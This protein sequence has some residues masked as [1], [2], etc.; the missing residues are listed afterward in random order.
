MQINSESSFKV[1]VFLT[2]L[3]LTLCVRNGSILAIYWWLIDLGDGSKNPFCVFLTAVRTCPE[4]VHQRAQ[5]VRSEGVD[6]PT[7]KDDPDGRGTWSP[8][9][10][11]EDP[12]R[13]RCRQ[14][15]VIS[16][17][18]SFNLQE[19]QSTFISVLANW[20]LYGLFWYEAKLNWILL[21]SI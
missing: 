11:V 5:S 13:D 8:I 3:I 18:E 12:Q 7:E 20:C 21:G 6:E 10:A 15:P 16:R 9:R 2:Q 4:R 1:I 19:T 17:T 14:C